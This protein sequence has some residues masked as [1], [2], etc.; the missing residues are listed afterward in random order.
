MPLQVKTAGIARCGLLLAAALI[1]SYIESVLGMHFAFLPGMKLGLANVITA[2]VFFEFSKGEALAV[3]LGRVIIMGILFGSPI[4]FLYSFCGAFLSFLG[5]ILARAI[6]KGISYVGSSV[7]C[8]CL[9]NLGQSIVATGFF[10]IDVASF[11]LPYLLL[12][13]AIFGTVTGILLNF[14][15][16]KYQ[17]VIFR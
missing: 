15:S 4:S 8:A 6:G 12:G 5:L 11:Y 10:G 3:S 9:H 17:K 14:I 1:L 16:K 13:G 7:L 2:F